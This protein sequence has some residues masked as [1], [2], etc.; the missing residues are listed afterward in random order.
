M[1]DLE[2]RRRVISDPKTRDEEVAA[3]V[4]DNTSNAKFLDDMLSLDARIEQAMRVDVPDD[5]ADKILFQSSSNVVKVSF[6]KRAL[7]IAATVAFAF[8]LAAGQINWGNFVAQPAHAGL[9]ATAIQHVHAEEPFVATINEHVTSVQINNKLSPFAYKLAQDFPY[10]VLY[11]NHCGFGDSV[12]L[13]MVFQGENGKVTLFLTTMMEEGET[14]LVQGDTTSQVLH[15]MDASLILVGEQGEDIAAI[16][17]QLQ[18]LF[19]P[20][21]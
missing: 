1:D 14:Q 17:Q 15:L 19:R 16:S 6:G 7:S 10:P 18:P 13:H 3:A 12:A 5:L 4:A 9:A 11:L 8:G 21:I 2:F 20:M